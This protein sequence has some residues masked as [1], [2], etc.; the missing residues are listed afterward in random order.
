MATARRLATPKPEPVPGIDTIKPL[1]DAY[2]TMLQGC[3]SLNAAM[4]D[5]AQSRLQQNVELG[6]ALTT[7]KGVE[8]MVELQSGFVR[9][10]VQQYVEQTDKILKL[11]AKTVADC[12]S[13]AQ[14]GA[15]LEGSRE[16]RSF[17]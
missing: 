2:S 9:S 8:Q 17:D 12:V 5:F 1:I 3:M 11:G 6:Q 4:V 10:A 16:G 15:K 13:V 7:L 14:E